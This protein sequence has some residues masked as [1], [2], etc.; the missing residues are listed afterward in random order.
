MIGFGMN[1]ILPGRAGEILRPMALAKQEG[2][3]FGEAGAGIFIGPSAIEKEICSMYHA[4]VVC[5][6]TDITER[7]YAIS[8]ERRI[9]HPA[10]LQI[11]EAARSRLF[12]S[13]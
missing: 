13:D 12:V 3:P 9:E 7:Y 5:R 6:T 10:V 4:G 11:T 8:P 1:G 2:V